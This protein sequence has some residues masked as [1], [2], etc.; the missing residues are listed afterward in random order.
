M[1]GGGQAAA[2][3]QKA[4]AAIYMG[5]T[6]AQ[7]W[8]AMEDALPAFG[9]Y[10]PCAGQHKECVLGGWWL[11][12]ERGRP[13]RGSRREAHATH[14]SAGQARSATGGSLHAAVGP[15]WTFVAGSAARCAPRTYRAA[16]RRA[17]ATVRILQWGEGGGAGEE[18]GDAV[19]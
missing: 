8:H 7:Y 15:R 13:A 16:Y 14:R 19:I 9:L 10:L 3:G 5:L 17:V 2:R 6:A 18:K 1:G 4:D 12:E 11:G